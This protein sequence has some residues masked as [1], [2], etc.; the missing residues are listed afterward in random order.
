MTH[1]AQEPTGPS[2]LSEE[3][4]NNIGMSIAEIVP[5]NFGENYELG[6]ALLRVAQEA[7][8]NPRLRVIQQYGR[9]AIKDSVSEQGLDIA[10]K[11]AARSFQNETRHIERFDDGEEL[12]YLSLMTVRSAAQ[13]RGL[14]DTAEQA[15][16]ALEARRNS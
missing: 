16:H 10:V 6:A 11:S 3:D 9:I 13:A 5:A 7:E 12:D 14:E 8:E 4:Y 15:K 2:D 1:Y